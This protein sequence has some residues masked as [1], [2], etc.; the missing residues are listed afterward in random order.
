MKLFIAD[1]FTGDDLGTEGF[2]GEY[3]AAE[4]V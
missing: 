2:L 4:G 1:I 3:K